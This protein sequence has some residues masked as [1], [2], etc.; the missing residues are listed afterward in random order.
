MYK[1]Q[2]IHCDQ[3]TEKTDAG[4]LS[5]AGAGVLF[6]A[7]LPRTNHNKRQGKAKKIK[8]AP[9]TQLSKAAS[10]TTSSDGINN[11]VKRATPRLTQAKVD[12]LIKAAPKTQLSE[13]AR[14][15]RY[16]TVS[17]KADSRAAY[18]SSPASKAIS[19]NGIHA[20]SDLLILYI[21]NQLGPLV[22]TTPII[23]YDQQVLGLLIV[24]DSDLLVLYL[25]LIHI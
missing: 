4:A 17:T 9:R 18:S 20:S 22:C 21:L 3:T 11:A 19:S 6:I 8:V 7:N 14:Q 1:R 5:V 25:S 16:A 12:E 10:K 24:H 2:S 13:T 15:H 23:N